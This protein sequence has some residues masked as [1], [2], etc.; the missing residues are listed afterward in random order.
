MLKTVVK[1][2]F[3]P[4]GK[5]RITI[6][7]TSK[8]DDGQNALFLKCLPVFSER[9]ITFQRQNSNDFNNNVSAYQ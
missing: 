9:T 8:V 7:M 5:K 2:S 3:F 1:L 6:E 4:I